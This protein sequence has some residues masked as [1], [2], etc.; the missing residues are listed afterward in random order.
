M[1]V[2]MAKL[3]TR[4]SNH[5]G[6]FGA[7]G[8]YAALIVVWIIAVWVVALYIAADAT[9]DTGAGAGGNSFLLG[10]SLAT[11]GV[12]TAFSLKEF[13]GAYSRWRSARR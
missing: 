7:D 12:I 5:D 9:N 2:A 1:E 4:D 10:C 6:R 8:L 13:W 3:A 11:A